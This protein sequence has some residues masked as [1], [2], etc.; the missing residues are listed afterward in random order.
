MVVD[1]KALLPSARWPLIALAVV[2][3]LSFGMFVVDCA[4]THDTRTDMMID[5]GVGAVTLVLASAIGVALVRSLKQRRALVAVQIAIINDRQRELEAFAGRVAHNLRGPLQPILGYAD[6]LAAGSGPPPREIGV[7]L[8][9]AS[10]RL[11]EIVD[12]LLELSISGHPHPGTAEVAPVVAEVVDAMTPILGDARLEL[13]VERC[14]AC[15]SSAVLDQILRNLVSNAAKYRSPER[16]LVVAISA[17]PCA[18]G[19]E[20]A[21]ADNGI[22]MDGAT[23]AHAFEPWYRASAARKIPGHGLGLSIVKRTVDALGGSCAIDSR[24][25]AGTRF[26][27]RLPTAL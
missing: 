4:I 7:R 15:C 11:G 23:A 13:A 25:G 3:V 1:E 18:S 9:R 10:A 17:C 20:I 8:G 2:V 21:V 12:E 27:V 26:I 6:L 22:G 16:T 14:T 19:I 24:L 5:G